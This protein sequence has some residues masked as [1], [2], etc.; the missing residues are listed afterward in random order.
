ML[1][2]SATGVLASFRSSTLRR[3]FSEIRSII[4]DFP[5]AKI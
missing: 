1:K 2:K 4:G 5:F 3:S